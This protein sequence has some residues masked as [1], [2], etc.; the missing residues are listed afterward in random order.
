MLLVEL[1]ETEVVSWEASR[2]KSDR[3]DSRRPRRLTRF[4]PERVRCCFLSVFGE[5]EEGGSAAAAAAASAAKADGESGGE[6][7]VRLRAR[8]CRI[9]LLL[10]LPL[11][12]IA[13]VD[14][15]VG[16]AGGDGTWIF[17]SM[18]V[19][20]RGREL[21]LLEPGRGLRKLSGSL[22]LFR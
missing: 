18:P 11:F 19:S 22:G 15:D 8:K 2:L 3:D 14:E 10:L 6:E 9:M 4:E 21:F 1:W 5:R 16:M 20:S 17:H 7:E 13:G 12:V